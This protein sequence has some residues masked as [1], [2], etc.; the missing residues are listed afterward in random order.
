MSSNTNNGEE[1]YLRYWLWQRNKR[2]TIDIM[3]RKECNNNRIY[4]RHAQ[5]RNYLQK[6]HIWFLEESY[7]K[8]R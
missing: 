4:H 3:L 7:G 2:K 6:S 5:Q 1:Y 8:V